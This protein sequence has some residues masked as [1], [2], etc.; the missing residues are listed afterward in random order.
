MAVTN[1]IESAFDTNEQRVRVVPAASEY[2][3]RYR[4]AKIFVEVFLV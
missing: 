4:T 3:Y 2:G 1:L